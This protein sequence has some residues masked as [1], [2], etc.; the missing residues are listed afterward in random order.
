MG[1]AVVLRA[2]LCL[3]LILIAAG[4]TTVVT[5]PVPA[6]AH[7]GCTSS[8]D[9][10]SADATWTPGTGVSLTGR[11]LYPTGCGT[12]PWPLVLYMQGSNS[13]R[14]DNINWMTRSQLAALGFVVVSFNGRGFPNGDS[15]LSCTSATDMTDAL[16]DSGYDASGP[17][18]KLDAKNVIDWAIAGCS[19]LCTSKVDSANIGVIGYSYNG[20][21]TFLLPAYDSRIDAIIPVAAPTT[22]MIGAVNTISDRPPAEP[23]SATPTAYLHGNFGWYGHADP[24]V[25]TAIADAIRTKYLGLTPSSTTQ[26]FFNDR[27]VL[28]D[29]AAVDKAHLITKPTFVVAGF[30]DQT[31][32]PTAQIQ[33]WKKLPTGDRYLYVGACGHSAWCRTNDQTTLRNKVH[34]FLDKYLKASGASLGGPVFFVTPPQ[35][36]VDWGALTSATD[37]PPT[38]VAGSP[39]TWYLR[40]S[41][42]LSL[43]AP[44]TSEAADNMSNPVWGS[45]SSVATA[46]DATLGYST[47][48]FV[49]YT[50]DQAVA[51][52][53][54][55]LVEVEA[56]L[57]LSST[58]DRLQVV[59]DVFRVSPT[60]VES[61]VF[62]GASIVAPTARGQAAGTHV[63][64]KFRAGGAGM[65]FTLNDKVRIKVATHFKGQYAPEPF[66]G[67]YSAYHT[68]SEPSSVKFHWAA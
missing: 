65:T 49:Q 6:A 45:P 32:N 64:F 50:T 43:T 11:V 39:Q 36:D 28:D 38:E 62:Q 13:S 54:L 12:G 27:T 23:S 25:H 30:R 24:T 63:R 17:N 2:R 67:T 10:T 5:H 22:S 42:L 15:A 40:S 31:V 58:T 66:P 1:T 60:N 7:S 44:S 16:N 59:V 8:T 9:G 46:C 41:N 20:T 55:K 68:T 52:S 3:A 35:T 56:D 47:G 26:T 37:W 53:I 21:R 48:Q 57:W 61:R 14:C 33:T 51:A 29:S 34:D 19:T 4:L 18:D